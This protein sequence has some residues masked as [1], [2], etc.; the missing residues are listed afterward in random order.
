MAVLQETGV[1][2][3][4]RIVS[5]TLPAKTFDTN[6][7]PSADSTRKLSRERDRYPTEIGMAPRISWNPYSYVQTRFNVCLK[8]PN[9]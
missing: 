7:S 6:P 3:Q 1:L 5:R 4:M 9:A 8:D 2:L